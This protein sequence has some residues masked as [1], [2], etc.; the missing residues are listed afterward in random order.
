MFHKN[1]NEISQP[2]FL[3]HTGANIVA[4]TKSYHN[5]NFVVKGNGKLKIGSYCAIGDGVKI[6]LS[7]HNFDY[8]SIQ[9]SIYKENFGG[10]PYE[11]DFNISEIGNDVWIGDNVL[12]LPKINIGNGVIVGGGAVVTKNIPDYAIVAGNPAKVI[13]YR[14]NDE[15]I[16]YLNQIKWWNWTSKEI[17]CN[18]DFFFKTPL[19]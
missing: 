1:E 8:P 17:L 6:I 11:L 5:G 2:P 16:K 19:E 18:R 13:K 15:Q 12:I 4:G 14:F 9:Y 10:Y 7:N 3:I